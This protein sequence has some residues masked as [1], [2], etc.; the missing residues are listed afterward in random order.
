[1]DKSKTKLDL[2]RWLV[3]ARPWHRRVLLL[4]LPIVLANLT[5]PLLSTVDTAIAGHLSDAASLGGVALGGLFFNICFWAFGFLR[6]GTSGLVAQAYGRKDD[7]ALRLHLLRGLATGVAIGAVLLAASPFLMSMAFHAI[8]G[9]AEVQTAGHAYSV[10]RIWSAPLALG[11]FVV[12]GYMLG[13][14][15]PTLALV[16]QGCINVTNILAAMAYVYGL[17]LGVAGL[18]YA[19]ATADLVGFL[20]GLALLWRLRPRGLAAWTWAEL[21]APAELLHLVSLN[22][23][24]FIRTLCLIGCFAWFTH[25]G[26]Q[27][28]DIVLGANALLLNF[29]TFMA[30]LLDGVAQAGETLVGAAIGARERRDFTLAVSVS[31][32]WGAVGAA[33]FCALYVFAGHAVVYAL[34]DIPAVRAMAL[35]YLPWAA[36][37]PLVSVW[38]YLLD[39]VF[40]GA[41]RSRD[42]RNAMILSAAT[43]AVAVSVLPVYFANN[44][45]WAALLVLMGMRGITLAFR[46]PG[47]TRER[48][49]AMAPASLS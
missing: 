28:G 6:M 4:A 34:T 9:S 24:I 47:L 7:A 40:I 8:G 30:Y 49:G 3:D 5:Q 39:G 31:A 44:G 18:G 19:T 32:L 13:R 36:A 16:V 10:A 17:K 14:Q 23:D 20:L 29:Q 25:E 38:S 46:L 15:R 27:A 41:T 48:F 1:V 42:M 37:S 43:Y 12:L 2:A 35:V 45:L 22:R 26:A 21:L 11:N 33:G